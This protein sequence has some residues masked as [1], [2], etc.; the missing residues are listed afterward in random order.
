MT[1]EMVSHLNHLALMQTTASLSSSLGSPP[2]SSSSD[3][4]LIVSVPF[5][6]I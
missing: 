2:S 1:V 4:E 5:K 3:L 6:I